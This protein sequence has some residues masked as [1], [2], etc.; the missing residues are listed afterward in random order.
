[1]DKPE[2]IQANPRVET[3]AEFVERAHRLWDDTVKYTRERIRNSVKTHIYIFGDNL[4]Q[5]GNGGQAQVCRGLPNCY[6]VPTKKSP[7]MNEGAFF[8]DAEYTANTRAISAA[9]QR[10][11]QDGR[12]AVILPQIGRGRA[13]MHIRAPRTYAFL[14]QALI[15][16]ER[17]R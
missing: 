14:L 16:F 17:S 12:Q 13:E 1:M 5:R 10:I 7:T 2:P 8:T 9:L 3:E 11:P 6:G 15:D 4:E